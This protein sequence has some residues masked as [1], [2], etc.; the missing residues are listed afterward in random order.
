MITEVER[1]SRLLFQVA[2]FAC[3]RFS[4]HFLCEKTA[5]SASFHGMKPFLCCPPNTR[6]FS[7]EPNMFQSGQISLR[8]VEIQA[9]FENYVC[10]FLTCLG[11]FQDS[12]DNVMSCPSLGRGSHMTHHREHSA[13]QIK[14][15]TRG[16]FLTLFL[17][18]Q[19]S[20]SITSNNVNR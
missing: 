1:K 20:N 7:Y 18:K 9:S 13:N 11:S 8:H 17:L 10:L 5:Y 19:L 15:C 3:S 4:L 16:V 12:Q 14:L 2:T 6:L